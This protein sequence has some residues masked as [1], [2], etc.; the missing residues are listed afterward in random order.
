MASPLMPEVQNGVMDHED[1]SRTRHTLLQRL[2]NLED[3]ASWQDFFETY[4]RLIYSTAIRARLTPEEAQDAVQETILSVAK[5]IKNFKVG[6][7][8]G[9]FKSWL[10]TL[11][12]WRI[13][14]QFRKR[15]PHSDNTVPFIQEDTNV[16]PVV[17]GIAD[18][19]SLEPDAKW[20][21]DWQQNLV[22]AAMQRVKTRVDPLDYQMF[23]LHVLKQWPASKV[24]S[25]LNV[26]LGNVFYAKYKISR[27]IKKEVKRLETNFV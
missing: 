10:L 6:A 25:M 20:E 11:T 26:K 21:T 3:D 23:D 4:W 2:K 17:E 8:H 9:S 16:T 7:E 14:D 22:D 15:P 5:N 24:A 12:R 1:L 18:P 19:A 27:L 13:N